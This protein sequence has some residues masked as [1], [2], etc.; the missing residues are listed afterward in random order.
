M[1]NL[2]ITLSLMARFRECATII[3]AYI[4]YIVTSLKGSTEYLYEDVY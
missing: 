1:P 4:R 3:A 2:W